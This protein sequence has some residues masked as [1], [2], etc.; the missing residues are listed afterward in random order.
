MIQISGIIKK[1]VCVFL[2][3]MG[4]MF[5]DNLPSGHAVS[6][7]T[8]Q[9]TVRQLESRWRGLY[10]KGV[11]AF[12]RQ[13]YTTAE[14]A[15]K[16]SIELLI[17]ND[18]GNSPSHIY[19]LIKLG[20]VRFERGDAAGQSEVNSEIIE[21]ERFIRP[22]S[23]RYVEY[24]YNRGLYYSNVGRFEDAAATLEQALSYPEILNQMPGEK[25]KILH[26]QALC[27]YCLGS[28]PEAIRLAETCVSYDD[29]KTP[30]YIKSLAYY[31][32]RASD[33][34]KLE[35]LMPDCYDY[36]REQILR[37]FNQ[38]RASERASFWT[39]SGL[40]FTDYLPYY[41]SCHPS[42]ILVSF[43]YDAALFGKGVLLA[44][45]NKFT[46]LTLNSDDPE[47]IKVHTRY[48]ELKGKK[49][50]S[51]DEEFEM[52]ALSDVLL[53]FQQEHKN[54]YRRDFRIRWMDVRDKLEDGDIA[55]EFLTVPDASGEEEY[56]ALTLKKG[57]SSPKLTML[58]DFEELS[59]VSAESVY[60]TSLLYDMVWGPLE[61]EL[62]G[63]RNVFFSPAG[64]FYNTAIEY[65][66]NED[67]INFSSVRN[68]CRL[69]STKE[70]VLAENV[71]L[72]KGV[73]FGGVDYDTKISVL[74]RQSPE[75]ERSSDSWHGVP[76]DSLDFRGASSGGFAFLEGTMEEA[77]EISLICLDAD[78]PVDMFS[79]EEGSE[80]TF[81]NLTGTDV[82]F[83]H[84][85]TH[86]FYYASKTPGRARTLEKLFRDLNLHFVSED[87]ETVN[88]D[89]MLTRSGL[90][91]A[92]ANYVLSRVPVPDGVEDGVL[93]AA[94]IANIDLGR[95]RLLVLS[96]CQSG[97][98][99]VAA[100]EGVFGLQRGFKLAGVGSI[101]M[102]LWKVNDEATKILMTEMYRNV[103]SGQA[104][105]VALTNAQMSLRMYEGGLY[106]DPQ[107]WAAFV[108]LDGIGA[109]SV[110]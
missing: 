2:L 54:D 33:W 21:M 110:S 59:S 12:Q 53:R 36:S 47:L 97:L 10:K 32:F 71:T 7:Q 40:F 79:G 90:A 106:D 29:N 23:K 17:A 49:G 70:L 27:R 72:T 89:K 93:Y 98:G 64:M 24:L 94:E 81:K 22:G 4:L 30:D 1:G 95:V 101:V 50:R 45:E 99:D 11:D 102:S 73:L 38:S 16:E 28:L 63:V 75:Y 34:V 61:K 26:R 43:A 5:L 20:E 69:S 67:E 86:G 78:I 91:L 42:D 35:A 74:A 58:P 9:L 103:V 25:C 56:L 46:E 55:I 44:A 18:A 88:E 84:I 8:Q 76:L 31:Y 60:T 57:Y 6:R 87:V 96:A 82:D 100:S 66:P 19:S 83:L 80:T 39:T 68:V 41:A 3:L 48:L 85:A 108:L 65:L 52:Q 62:E 104:L 51:I 77:G 109:E 105:P 92:G 37:K 107:Y 14:S 15:L 13:D